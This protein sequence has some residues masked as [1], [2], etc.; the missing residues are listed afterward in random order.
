MRRAGFLAVG[1]L[2]GLALASAPAFAHCT[3]RQE[4]KVGQGPT[5]T[6]RTWTVTA[7]VKNN[8]PR[9]RNCR[10][11]L[12]SVN[13]DVPGSVS[14]G[15]STSIPSG[16]HVGERYLG[17]SA[18][19]WGA[20]KRMSVLEGY[21]DFAGV[22]MVATMD[23]G[24]KLKIHP[25]AAPPRLRRHAHWLGIFRYFVVYF[26]DKREVVS[27]SAFNRHGQQIAQAEATEHEFF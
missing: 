5:P 27:L 21:T 10:N 4:T 20:P 25:R 1:L 11:W 9:G 8:I 16:G 26:A 15:I 19:E 24:S 2:L 13:F 18:A 7:S 14:G 12:F 6:G 23:D 22:R 17:I 3:P